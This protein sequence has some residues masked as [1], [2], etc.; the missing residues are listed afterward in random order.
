[1]GEWAIP[2]EARYLSPHRCEVLCP[3]VVLEH[4]LHIMTEEV[5]KR[6]ARS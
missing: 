3:I 5:I 4:R 1:M 6:L 2:D